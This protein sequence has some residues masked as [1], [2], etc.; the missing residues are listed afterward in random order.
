MGELSKKDA[1]RFLELVDSVLYYIQF[2]LLEDLK[3]LLF[4]YVAPTLACLLC[5]QGALSLLRAIYKII[6]PPDAA[7]LHR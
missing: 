5:A 3:W 4:Q 1:E 7:E 6:F 2:Q